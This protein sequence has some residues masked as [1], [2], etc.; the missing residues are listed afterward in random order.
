M[1]FSA[2]AATERKDKSAIE[3]S[4]R[5]GAEAFSRRMYSEQLVMIGTRLA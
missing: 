3:E 2:Q 4:W 1:K 5:I